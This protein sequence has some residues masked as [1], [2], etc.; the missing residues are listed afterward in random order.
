MYGASGDASEIVCNASGAA[1][2]QQPKAVMVLFRES[3]HSQPAAGLN[4]S[5]GRTA[6]ATIL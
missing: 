1:P 6:N 2:G 5:R 3:S 4:K